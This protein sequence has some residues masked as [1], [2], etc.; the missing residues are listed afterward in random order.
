MTLCW[1]FSVPS[2][3][4]FK[5]HDNSVMKAPLLSFIDDKTGIERLRDLLKA[6]PSKWQD[7]VSACTPATARLL[8]GFH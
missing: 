3:Y 7:E 5:G 6:P 2:L 4:S 8:L 1:A